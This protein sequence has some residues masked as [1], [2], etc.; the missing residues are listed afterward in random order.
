M[1]LPLCSETHHGTSCYP[2]LWPLSITH[3]L[4]CGVTTAHHLRVCQVI[5]SLHRA[6]CY[7]S[8]GS[9]ARYSV[10]VSTTIV[11]PLSCAMW[12]R[13]ATLDFAVTSAVTYS[14]LRKDNEYC[15]PYVGVYT[16]NVHL[17]LSVCSR[18]AVV[19]STLIWCITPD[20]ACRIPYSTGVTN[21]LNKLR[22]E[23]YSRKYTALRCHNIVVD[24]CIC[25]VQ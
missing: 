15:M 5:D 2:H 3:V 4:R 23:L 10:T 9:S 25:W 8:T 7:A 22:Y 12:R 24:H 18:Y 11:A 17:H 1:E 16:P 6:S 20:S 14:T 21:V 13:P 19:L